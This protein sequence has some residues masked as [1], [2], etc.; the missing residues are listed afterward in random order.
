ME[1]LSEQGAAVVPTQTSV[2]GRLSFSAGITANLGILAELSIGEPVSRQDFPQSLPTPPT[3]RALQYVARMHGGSQPQLMKCSDGHYYVVKFGNN[4]QGNAILANELLAHQLA[5]FLGLPIPPCAVVQVNADLI[6]L[7]EEM[8]IE[9]K[10]TRVPCRPGL[11]FGSRCRLDARSP[12]HV[13]QI[14]AI[15]NRNDFLG[16]LVFDKWTCNADGRQVLFVGKSYPFRVEMIDNGFCFNG[17]HWNFPDSPVRGLYI[18][19]T[20]YDWCRGINSFDPWLTR[21]EEE[22]DSTILERFASHIPSDWYA[23]D[24]EHLAFLLHRLDRRR[25]RVRELLAETMRYAE[26]GVPR[27]SLRRA[28]AACL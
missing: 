16:M 5:T 12:S 1:P 14:S 9:T 13:R 8:V 25:C 23:A 21:I 4:P 7:S 19:Q 22:F 15:E 3:I 6:A 28:E 11:A 2:D 24:N 17:E 26:A 10:R 18:D 27:R 20:V